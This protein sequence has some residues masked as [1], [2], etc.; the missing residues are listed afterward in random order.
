M[1]GAIPPL[2]QYAFVAWCPVKA[3]GKLYLYLTLKGWVDG[4]WNELRQ[5][6]AQ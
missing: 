4:R 3:Q 6:Y 1:L 2:T 5:D